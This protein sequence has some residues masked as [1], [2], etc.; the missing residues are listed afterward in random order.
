MSTEARISVWF[1]RFDIQV[2]VGRGLT[3]A[4]RRA[5]DQAPGSHANI[6]QY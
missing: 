6:N 4:P 1:S 3:F 2:L 5:P